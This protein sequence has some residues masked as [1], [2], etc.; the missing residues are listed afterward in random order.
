VV[1]LRTARIACRF[2]KGRKRSIPKTVP[3]EEAR[4]SPLV[5][6]AKKT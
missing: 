1:R 4:H 5:M 6:I 3:I 2:S